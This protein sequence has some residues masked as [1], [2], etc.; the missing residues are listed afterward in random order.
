MFLMLFCLSVELVF[1]ELIVQ[2]TF[3]GNHQNIDT[4]YASLIYEINCQFPI[5]GNV[6][7]LGHLFAQGYRVTSMNERTTDAWGTS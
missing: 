2:Q 6:Q 1:R 4:Q 7:M 3:N 5:C